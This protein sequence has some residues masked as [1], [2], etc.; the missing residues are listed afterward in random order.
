VAFSLHQYAAPAPREEAEREMIGER[1]ARQ[2]DGGLLAEHH[3]HSLFEPRNDTI[4]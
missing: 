3:R 4:S 1:P 2:K